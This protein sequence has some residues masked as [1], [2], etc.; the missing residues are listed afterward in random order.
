MLL[1]NMLQNMLKF[2]PMSLA[3]AMAGSVA[4]GQWQWLQA[5]GKGAEHHVMFVLHTVSISGIDVISI[6]TVYCLPY[7]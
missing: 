4:S 5:F 2:C 3:L 1:G 6:Q 7:V